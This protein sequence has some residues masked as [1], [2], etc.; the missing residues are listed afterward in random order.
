MLGTW[1]GVEAES[2][3]MNHSYKTCKNHEYL[4]SKL[5]NHE[6]SYFGS[7]GSDKIHV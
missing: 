7:G 6:S 5:G 3:I 4:F 2:S 1:S